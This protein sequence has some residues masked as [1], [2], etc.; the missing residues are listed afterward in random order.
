M[1]A[2]AVSRSGWCRAW[3]VGQ[4]GCPWPRTR[5]RRYGSARTGRRSR[6][7]AGCRGS[8]RRSGSRGGRRRRGRRCR[9]SR[10]PVLARRSRTTKYDPRPGMGL[11]HGQVAGGQTLQDAPP[12]Q[13]GGPRS[14][15]EQGGGGRAGGLAEH[16]DVARVPAEGGDVLLNP[17]ERGELVQQAPIVRNP[18]H[19]AEPLETGAVVEGDHDHAGSS[20]D[21][22][23]VLRHRRGAVTP[24]T[25]V[26]PHHHRHASG[27]GGR[28]PHVHRQTVQAV[29]GPPHR[30]HSRRRRARRRT[31]CPCRR[32]RRGR[33]RGSGRTGSSRS[34]PYRLS[35]QA[36]IGPSAG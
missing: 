11:G 23:V 29:A 31:G 35:P 19:V 2:G 14:R 24:L 28:G 30:R 8:G 9:G 36:R 33:G 27:L 16:G 15:G 18:R 25:A 6:P 4:P 10:R 3:L 34:R 22:P 1:S 20:E 7:E 12:E 17:G 21:A 26:D 13:A 5:S 32:R